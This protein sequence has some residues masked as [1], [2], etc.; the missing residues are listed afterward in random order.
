MKFE[1]KAINYLQF[2]HVVSLSGNETITVVMCQAKCRGGSEYLEKKI[3][4][5]G[6]SLD[7]SGN[8]EAPPVNFLMDVTL[9]VAC[10]SAYNVLRFLCSLKYN[11]VGK[12]GIR[13]DAGSDAMI[14]KMKKHFIET[15]EW[16]DSY[17]YQKSMEKYVPTI[18]ISKSGANRK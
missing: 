13:F 6:I 16:V 14:I 3:Y 11:S 5:V 9:D 4:W 2:N 12:I 8:I 7:E 1:E 17:E 15:M 10:I 18:K